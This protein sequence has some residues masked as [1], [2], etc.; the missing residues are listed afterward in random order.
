MYVFG[1]QLGTSSFP[2]SFFDGFFALT[3]CIL[4]DLAGEICGLRLCAVGNAAVLQIPH[5]LQSTQ[6]PTAVLSHQRCQLA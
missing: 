3:R 4:D 6:C 5:Y 1:G 2:F